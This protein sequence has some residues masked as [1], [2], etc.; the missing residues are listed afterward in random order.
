MIFWSPGREKISRG[1][2]ILILFFGTGCAT[3]QKTSEGV[4]FTAYKN[5]NYPE[6]RRYL[7]PQAKDG[8]AFAQFLV[9]SMHEFGFG[10]EKNISLAL[11]WYQL[12]AGS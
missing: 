2:V 6:A 10:G 8:N 5:E 11:K 4:G 1:I 3:V 7:L 12:A 9:G